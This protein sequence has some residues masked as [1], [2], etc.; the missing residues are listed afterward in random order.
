M[1]L[2]FFICDSIYLI[3][4][5]FL[6]YFIQDIQGQVRQAHLPKGSASGSRWTHVFIT[7][8]DEWGETGGRQGLRHR[9]RM[10]DAFPEVMMLKQD[11]GVRA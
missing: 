1:A 5:K 4:I 10:R 7:Q 2:V 3:Y 8:G 6:P 11:F 9:L